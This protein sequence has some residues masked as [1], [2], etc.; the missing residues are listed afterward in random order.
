MTGPNQTFPPPLPYESA[1]AP[2]DGEGTHAPGMLEVTV[3]S[4]ADLDDVLENAIK[5]ITKSAKYH[6]VGIMVTR[7]GVGRYVVRAHPAVPYGLIR[8][9][10]A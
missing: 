3:E 5:L 8:Q 4:G 6:Q 1:A 9:R 10:H 2:A 7:T